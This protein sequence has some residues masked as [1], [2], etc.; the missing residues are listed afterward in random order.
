MNVSTQ[1]TIDITQEENVKIICGSCERR[2]EI[3]WRECQPSGFLGLIAHIRCHGVDRFVEIS[4]FQ[5]RVAEYCG[6]PRLV[7]LWE[8]LGDMDNPAAAARFLD[9]RLAEIASDA[10]RNDPEIAHVI[11]RAEDLLGARR[12]AIRRF[13]AAKERACASS[14]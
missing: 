14:R 2:V 7:L 1:I 8:Q 3:V 4:Q 9:E 12:D 10:R 6:L 11:R 5:V 13:V